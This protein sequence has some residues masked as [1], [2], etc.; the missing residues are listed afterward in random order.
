MGHIV[1]LGDSIFDNQAYVGSNPD[2]IT[3]LKEKLPT[4][5][6]A[7]LRASDGDRMENIADQIHNLP[8]DTSHI[9]VS[10]GGNNAL[11]HIEILNSEG[12]MVSNV[13]DQLHEI[14]ED[15]QRQYH[16]MVLALSHL[17]PAITLCT[18]YN[19]C[20]P[21]PE[22][23]NRA[24]TA[25]ALF[26]DII[27]YEAFGAGIPLLDLRLVCTEAQDYANPIEPSHLGG[28]KITTCISKIIIEHDFFVKQTVAY[29]FLKHD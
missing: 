19:P 4:G 2:V 10:V 1:L 29:P 28:E 20:F 22:M 7:S 24:T 21:D 3:Q 8:L 9:I 17:Q 15:F 16:Q 13:L 14:R 23:Q 18:I 25:L 12:G 5:W 27:I 26:N 11:D 6:R